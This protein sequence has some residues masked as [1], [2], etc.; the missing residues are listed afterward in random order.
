MTIFNKILASLLLFVCVFDPQDQILGLKSVIFILLIAFTI[1]SG[2][3]KS[4]I[5]INVDL[6]I[7]ILLFLFIPFISTLILFIRSFDVWLDLE[8]LSYLK[9]FAFLLF[10]II[11]SSNNINLVNSFKKTLNILALSTILIFFIINLS[12]QLIS[13][14]LKVGNEI[15]SFAISFRDYKLI[16]FYNV[17]FHT[18]P[19]LIFNISYYS[20][21][22][23]NNKK[24]NNFLWFF[25]IYLAMLFSGTRNNIIFSTFIIIFYFISH[26][27][28]YIIIMLLLVIF[29]FFSFKDIFNAM[30]SPNEL[31]NKIKLSYL[32]DYFREY[33][34]IN[35]LFFGQGLGS[36]FFVKIHNTYI[37]NT[38]L[39]YFEIFRRYGLFMGALMI[40]LLYYPIIK[41]FKYSNFR[42]LI[43]A[44][45][46]YLLM[47]MTNPF[48]FSSNGIILLSI[49]LLINEY[50]K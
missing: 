14:F 22:L 2:L 50:E 34:D 43:Y 30:F 1:I 26:N 41:F 9:T 16:K 21:E 36:K 32:S 6:L 39:T 7:Y 35:T 19:L 40:F 44:Y 10:A 33:S 37:S 28:K 4:K 25:I 47:I 12:P 24:I 23:F 15:G 48:F 38:E 18:S 11:L 29:I 5:S 27:K 49:V 13:V 20:N 17:Y 45:T 8:W 31:S 46:I 3:Y 42:W